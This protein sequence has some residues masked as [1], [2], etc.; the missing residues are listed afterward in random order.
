MERPS[1][2]VTIDGP[3]GSGKSTVARMLAERIGARLLDTGA[4]Y[5]SVALAALEKGVRLEDGAALGALAASLEIALTQEPDGQ[6]VLLDGRDVTEAIRTPEVSEAASR[7]S[8]HREVREVLLGIQRKLASQGP[9]VAEG[10]DMGTVV[11]PEAEAK[12][13]LS[14]EERVR[15]ERRWKQLLDKGQSVAFEDVLEEQR[16]RDRRDAE[17]EVAPL[18]P[19]PDAVILDSTHMTP[20]RVVEAML[21]VLRSRGLV[22]A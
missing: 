22:E 9:S 3:A 11:F 2:V 5:R 7:V 16:R 14:A 12:F 10:R 4:L 6:H 21:Q 1:F 8:A 18:R 13:F 19:A 17:R 20:E 15:A